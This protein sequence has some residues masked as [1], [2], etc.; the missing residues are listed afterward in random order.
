MAVA[1]NT[2]FFT[3][4]LKGYIQQEFQTSEGLFIM[5]DT[6][7][8]NQYQIMSALSVTMG[9]SYEQGLAYWPALTNRPMSWT[10]S[11]LYSTGLRPFRGDCPASIRLY[12]HHLLANKA[13]QWYQ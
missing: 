11:P 6:N 3:T 10:V 2:L 13:G 9:S 1:L 5:T 12:A 7:S 4:T 8:C